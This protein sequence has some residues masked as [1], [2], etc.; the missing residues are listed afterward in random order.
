MASATEIHLEILDQPG[1]L[2]AVSELLGREGIN[3][4]GFSVWSGKARFLVEDVD[5]ALEILRREGLECTTG[6]VLRLD[7]PDEPGTLAELAHELGRAGINIDYAYTVNPRVEGAAS[8]VLS[9]V[10][11]RQAEEVLE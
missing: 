9:V 10:D 6:E 3:I 1:N 2:G 8:F 5:R 4:D 7:V 11:P